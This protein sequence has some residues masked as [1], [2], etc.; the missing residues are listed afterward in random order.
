MKRVALLLTLS[1]CLTA[2]CKTRE[3][4]A[5]AIPAA[6][7]TPPPTGAAAKQAPPPTAP[8]AKAGGGAI[9]VGGK[10]TGVKVIKVAELRRRAEELLGTAVA[11]E[12]NVS[13]YC[14]HRKRWFAVAD[15]QSGTQL[16][17]LT[18][19]AFLVPDG[20][21][22]RRVRVEGIVEQIELPATRARHMAKEHKLQDPDRV[23]GEVAREPVL[24]A[25]AAR[26]E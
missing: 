5:P 7:Q 25:A 4:T 15:D 8:A 1:L 19:P 2:A 10:F 13:A 9:H 20:V 16:R 26:F 17:V 21:M 24:R 23:S 22:G 14:H 6:K 11:L 3:E 18:V 12:G